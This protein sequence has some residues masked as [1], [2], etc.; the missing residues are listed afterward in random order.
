MVVIVGRPIHYPMM[1]TN[2]GST[3]R[4]QIRLASG[5][6]GRLKRLNT[7]DPKPSGNAKRL[8]ELARSNW[9]AQTIQGDAVVVHRSSG[10]YDGAGGWTR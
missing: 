5:D 7:C 6:L 9:G 2:C 8:S 1:V 3:H 10:K 4:E